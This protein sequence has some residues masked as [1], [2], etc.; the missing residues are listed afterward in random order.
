MSIK[1]GEVHIMVDYDIKGCFSRPFRESKFNCELTLKDYAQHSSGFKPLV[2]HL[3]KTNP[4]VAFFNQNELFCDANKCSMIH[5]GMPL[6]RD[7]YHHLSEYGS[8]ELSNIF[9][10]W[11]KINTPQLFE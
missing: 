6:F 7:E 4:N 5:N 1:A 11:A 9:V 2:R 10:G 3:S 8:I